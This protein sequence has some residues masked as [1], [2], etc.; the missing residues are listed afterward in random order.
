M[1]C[2]V[3]FKRFELSPSRRSPSAAVAGPNW[4]QA[5]PFDLA[6]TAADLRRY[7]R[8]PGPATTRSKETAAT[9]PFI[10]RFTLTR[11]P[12]APRASIRKS[13]TESRAGPFR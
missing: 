3:P 1:G 8:R 2:V 4:P 12:E 7:L 10:S 13:M 5:T 11:Q 6:A 9:L